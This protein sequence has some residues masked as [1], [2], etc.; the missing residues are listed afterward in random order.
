MLSSTCIEIIIGFIPRNLKNEIKLFFFFFFFP[1]QL[2]LITFIPLP[3]FLF[4]LFSS[5]AER[6]GKVKDLMS[7]LALQAGEVN[8]LDRSKKKKK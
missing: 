4:F 2:P 6:K 1:L 3:T 8:K 7:S 5:D